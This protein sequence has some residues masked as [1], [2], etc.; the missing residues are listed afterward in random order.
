[1]LPTTADLHRVFDSLPKQAPQSN[2]S[3]TP[4]TGC[5]DPFPLPS[6]IALRRRRLGPAFRGSPGRWPHWTLWAPVLRSRTPIGL[7]PEPSIGS[8]LRV[9]D[10]SRNP[11]GLSVRGRLGPW[12]TGHG[13]SLS[14]G[15]ANGLLSSPRRRLPF[16]Q[17]S[18]AARTSSRSS[19]SGMAAA[20]SGRSRIVPLLVLNSRWRAVKPASRPSRHP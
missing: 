7:C 18:R 20:S 14:R 5:L 1:V 17:A 15:R 10:R 3:V 12:K 11:N 6:D 16:F 19:T 9:P 2:R 13:A 4:H 8:P